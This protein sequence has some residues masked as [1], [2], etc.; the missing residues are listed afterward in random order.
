MEKILIFY[1]TDRNVELPSIVKMDIGR[2]LTNTLQ[3][4]C[5]LSGK[6]YNKIMIKT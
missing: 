5:W 1:V 3:K 6:Y 2:D 4:G